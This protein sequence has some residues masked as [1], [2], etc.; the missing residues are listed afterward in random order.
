MPAAGGRRRRYILDAE[1]SGILVDVGTTLGPVAFGAT[2][3]EGFVEIS[4]RDGELD[5]SVD[6][7]AHVE[8][9][10]SRLTSGNSAY[11]G[12]LRRQIGARRFPAAY[13]DLHRARAVEG[14]AGRYRVAGEVTLRGATEAVEGVVSVEFP[15][16]DSLVV[17][18]RES[19]DI[20]MFNIPA[21]SLF[22]MR[23]EPSVRLSLQL[24]AHA[25]EGDS[26]G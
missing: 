13:L 5:L 8:L 21:P 10:V 7:V 22:M 16:P 1:R 23:I 24:E 17:V 25:G 11:D 12:E 26:A 19:F 20:R 18:G 3:L 6:P 2:G 15:D 4:V 9:Q 14:T